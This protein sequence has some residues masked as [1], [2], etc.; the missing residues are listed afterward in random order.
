[1]C[2]IMCYVHVYVCFMNL[3]LQSDH[4]REWNFN[5][6]EQFSSSILSDLWLLSEITHNKEGN[7]WVWRPQWESVKTTSGDKHGRCFGSWET[8]LKGPARGQVLCVLFQSLGVPP[9]IKRALVKSLS[10]F[11]GWPGNPSRGQDR[12]RHEDH[13]GATS[14]KT[15]LADNRKLWHKTKRAADKASREAKGP[16]CGQM[17][18][19]RAGARFGGQTLLLKQ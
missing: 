13:C 5:L 7:S 8:Y 10:G 9:A 16:M 17:S 18:T 12:D 14:F 4:Q 2:N 15:L 11:H 1:M 6:V 19:M 3:L